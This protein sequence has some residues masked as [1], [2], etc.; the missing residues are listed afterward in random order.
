[1]E[2]EEEATSSTDKTPEDEKKIVKTTRDEVHAS[3]SEFT[4]PSSIAYIPSR[5][6]EALG[7]TPGEIL[8]M[9]SVS[10]GKAKS[11]TLQ[12]QQHSWFEI[13]EEERKSLLEFYLRSYQF[14][15]LG[16]ILNIP[17]VGKNYSILVKK[18][19]PDVGAVSITDTDLSTEVVKPE[20]KAPAKV[21]ETLEIDDK[22]SLDLLPEKY[23]FAEFKIEDVMK[24]YKLSVRGNSMNVGVDMYISTKF[25]YP[26]HLNFEKASQCQEQTEIVLSDADPFFASGTVYIGLRSSST[27]SKINIKLILK[28]TSRGESKGHV[29]GSFNAVSGSLSKCDNCQ[30]MIPTRTLAMHK[31]QCIRRNAFCKE[32]NVVIPRRHFKRHQSLVHSPVV[33]PDCGEKC[34]DQGAL[35][36]H[37]LRSCKHRIVSCAFCAMKLRY[38]ERDEHQK[39]CGMRPCICL[40]CNQPFKK[41]EMRYHLSS[42]HGMRIEDVTF[43]DYI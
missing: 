37:R 40:K 31:L 4:A 11:I 32:C 33:C 15:E 28:A 14:L 9:E 20:G 8:N 12:P 35:Q 16:A 5:V 17:Y 19:Q 26:S 3:V 13:D 36:T 1:M 24:G 23:T 34:K 30:R 2:I 41:R 7:A 29:L 43:R 27:T 38:F 6:L 22:V 25:K 39:I 42:V 21:H 10:L 18:L